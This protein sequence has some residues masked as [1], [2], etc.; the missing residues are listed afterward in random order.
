MGKKWIVL[1]N[2]VLCIYTVA[3][4]V[5][6]KINKAKNEKKKRSRCHHINAPLHKQVILFPSS[7][8]E[9]SLHDDL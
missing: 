5:A 7:S 3:Y 2:K 4:N 9:H 1:I 8:E 6:I